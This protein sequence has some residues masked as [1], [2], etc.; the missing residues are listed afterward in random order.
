MGTM[1]WS[2]NLEIKKKLD[3]LSNKFGIIVYKHRYILKLIN[4]YEIESI[5]KGSSLERILIWQRNFKIAELDILVHGK[6]LQNLSALTLHKS[7]KS[8]RN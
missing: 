7:Y 3:E 1:F 4:R 5:Y 2:M 8:L 6:M